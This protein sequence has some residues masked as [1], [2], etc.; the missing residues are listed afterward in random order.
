MKL[1]NILILLF[2]AI[3]SQAQEP[4]ECENKSGNFVFTPSTQANTINWRAFPEFN[5][6][7]KI[8][9]GGPHYEANKMLPLSRGFSH[10]STFY[11]SGF[12]NIP[13][14]NRAFIYYGVA[15][16]DEKPQPWQLIRSPWN[17]D[18]DA[19]KNKWKANMLQYS[20]FF[21]D[22]A[23]TGVPNADILMLDIERHWEG[24]FDLASNLAILAE[25]RNPLTPTEYSQLS[26]N[27]YLHQYKI[28]MQ[29]LYSQ[30][31][32]YMKAEGLLKNIPN[33]GSY[34]DVPIRHQTFNIEGNTWPIWQVN[35]QKLSYL[36]KDP[37]TN[38]LG[39][40]YYDQLNMLNPT[41]YL[42]EE[43]GPNPK[44]KGGNYLAEALF[45]IEA[46]RAWSSKAIVPF[47][48]LRHENSNDS[49]PKFIKPYQAEALAIFPFFSGANGLWLW[50]N[51]MLFGQK[52]NFNIYEYFV[53]GLKKLADHKEFFTGDYKNIIPTPAHELYTKQLPVWRA[54]VK[55]NKI[56][57]AAQNPYASE[58]ENSKLTITYNN[59]TNTLNLKGREVFLCS[60]DMTK[61]TANEPKPIA[62]MRVEV[63]GNP[64][65]NDLKL[66]V[67][68]AQ[69]QLANIEILSST[70][71]KQLQFLQ[72]IKI[73]HNHIVLP[74]TDILP[75]TYILS[76]TAN[77]QKITKKI[78]L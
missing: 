54:V 64:V 61:I 13:I 66:K 8:I 31:L 52:T 63:L 7:F 56:L 48:W 59:W 75:G 78:T 24:E 76:I 14:K 45:Q 20:R 68:S 57:V 47:V 3:N 49:I 28:D 55:N 34:A 42:S 2:L 18:L 32:S 36:M 50:E 62:N 22:G 58:N 40:S 17:N 74:I 9:Y 69:N 25:K 15:Y 19:Y 37:T 65:K 60:F 39:G 70:G 51:P 30:P 29:K 53:N 1:K 77:K 46:N 21:N 67:W 16:L 38:T 73:G 10:I 27:D 35:P 26:D 43:Y 12:I 33:I 11:E 72:K 6:P 41:L 5:L 71:Q 44:A 23:A 4:F